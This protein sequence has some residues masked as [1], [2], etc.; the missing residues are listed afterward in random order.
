M[1]YEEPVIREIL[2]DLNLDGLTAIEKAVKLF[3]Y[4]R[5]SITYSTQIATLDPKIF[6]ASN[7]LLQEKSFCIPKALALCALARAVGIPA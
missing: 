4:V 2:S 7:T 6:R 5:D 3:Y 1:D